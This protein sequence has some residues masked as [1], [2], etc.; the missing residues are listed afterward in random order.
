MQ[1]SEQHVQQSLEIR[2]NV[3]VLNLQIT[4]AITEIIRKIT[5]APLLA[6]E[7]TLSTPRPLQG[8]P[9]P[10]ILTQ[11][12]RSRSSSR[13]TPHATQVQKNNTSRSSPRQTTHPQSRRLSLLRS[14]HTT[15]VLVVPVT[16]TPWS[17]SP[18][19][20]N[21]MWSLHT[22]AFHEQL[23]FN[24]V[25]L[26]PSTQ[27]PVHAVNAPSKNNM[28]NCSPYSDSDRSPP[29]PGL[30]SIQEHKTQ[31]RRSL[32]CD[33]LPALNHAP[34]PASPSKASTSDHTDLPDP[35]SSSS[36]E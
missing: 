22:S 18:L 5:G 19:P 9:K 7:P 29:P 1:H 33:L 8:T 26:E 35:E 12:M 10:H 31:I 20:S 23:A 27:T 32:I 36:S 13:Q 14:P 25:R 17:G 28:H 16:T 6:E 2:N 15:P 24:R 11:D 4:T 21:K 3:A 30:E 34:P